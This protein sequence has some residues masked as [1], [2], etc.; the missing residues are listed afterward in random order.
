MS[1]EQQEKIKVTFTEYDEEVD[2]G[3]THCLVDLGACRAILITPEYEPDG[4]LS[5]DVSLSQFPM[6]QVT[7][8]LGMLADAASRAVEKLEE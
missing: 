6:E 5:L 2:G 4:T 3:V 7:D 8:L 1:T